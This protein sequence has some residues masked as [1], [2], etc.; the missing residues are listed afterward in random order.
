MLEER[1]WFD[2]WQAGYGRTLDVPGV[3]PSQLP[4]AANLII[5]TIR[6][7][8][9]EVTLMPV[10]PLTN[11]ALAACLAPDIVPLV[12]SVILMGGTVG[13]SEPEFNF[14]C[15]PEAAQI[16]LSLDWP[17]QLI[18]LNITNQIK[19]SRA[20]FASLPDDNPA[21]ALLQE[22]APG[23][24]ERVEGMGWT[25]GGCAL[26]DAIAVA[27]M[28][29]PDLFTW[30]DIALSIELQDP[31]RRGTTNPLTATSGRA[32]QVATDADI[33]AVYDLVWSLLL[34]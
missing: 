34:G 33:A 23:W 1:T 8:P 13:S 25:D 7:H 5:D 31:A 19:F 24:I 26:H 32:M 2:D 17:I 16:A 15:D 12:K 28:L 9:G 6:A 14:R 20:D 4:M 29:R 21:L 10:G 30:Q 27:A 18:G 11:V 22:Q 3:M